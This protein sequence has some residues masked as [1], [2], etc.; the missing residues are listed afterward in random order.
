MTGLAFHF[1]RPNAEPPQVWLLAMPAEFTGEW[2]WDDLV[3]SLNQTLDDAR[4]RAVEPEHLGQKFAALLP[5]VL[6][7][8]SWSPMTI[9]AN[10]IAR[11][12]KVAQAFIN[13]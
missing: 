3:A 10:I 6:T 9:N 8:S 2:R 5:A 12:A 13:P 1:D 11:A 7:E 4:A